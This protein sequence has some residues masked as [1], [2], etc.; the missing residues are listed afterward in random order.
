MNKEI[1]L[2]NSYVEVYFVP[3]YKLIAVAWKESKSIPSDV[4]KETFIAALDYAEKSGFLNFMSDSRLGGLVSPADRKWFQ[5][6]AVPRAAR[7]GLKHAAVVI[8]KDPFKKYYMNAIL[9]VIM[10][11]ANYNMKIFHDYDE[12]IN[13]LISHNDY[14]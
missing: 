6:Y 1:I 8:K 7:Y 9:K 12:A 3:E 13:W 2:D 4:Y 11:K 14:K 10:I 5:D